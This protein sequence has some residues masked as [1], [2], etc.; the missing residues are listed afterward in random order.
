MLIKKNRTSLF[1]NRLK[2]TFLFLFS[3]VFSSCYFGQTLQNKKTYYLD[4]IFVG[5][6]KNKL[7][8]DRAFVIFNTVKKTSRV[9]SSCNWIKTGYKHNKQ[10]FSFTAI[11]PAEQPCPDYLD[12][13]EADLLENLPKI[14]KCVFT[15]HHLY[16]FKDSDTLLTFHD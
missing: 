14:N 12:G 2:L 6:Q 7:A 16:F 3:L 13:L 8:H 9:Y 15:K 11:K 10:F 1:N 5:A 4:A